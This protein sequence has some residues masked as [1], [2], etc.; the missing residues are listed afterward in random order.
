MLFFKLTTPKGVVV[1]AALDTKREP[2][3][4]LKFARKLQPGSVVEPMAEP[5]NFNADAFDGFLFDDE[6][7]ADFEAV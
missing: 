7:M 5:A 3:E 6:S 2:L 4:A 1:Q